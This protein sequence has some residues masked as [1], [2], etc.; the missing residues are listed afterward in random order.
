MYYHRLEARPS[1]RNT[2]GINSRKIEK[3][4]KK[5]KL[6]PNFFIERLDVQKGFVL[7][8]PRAEGHHK[9]ICVKT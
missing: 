8:P 9:M 3:K 1:P 5:K 6:I 4:K 2:E 7:S